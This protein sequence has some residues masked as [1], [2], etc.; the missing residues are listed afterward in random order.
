MPT[1][2]GHDTKTTL[3]TRL[4]AMLLHQTLH[5]LLAHA[6]AL[7]P[8]LAPNARPTIGSTVLCIRRANVN[9]QCFAARWAPW[10]YSPRPPHVLVV[11]GDP[12]AEHPALPTDRPA[13]PVA[14][15]KG[16]L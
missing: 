13:P 12:H 8:Q 3:A 6:N 16:V 2:G 14:L 1:V 10:A 9:Q 15:N 11:P 5:S 7:C 4:N